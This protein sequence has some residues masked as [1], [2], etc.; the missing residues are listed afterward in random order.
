MARAT[1][2]VR[3]PS[4]SCL[5]H[6]PVR[7]AIHGACVVTRTQNRDLTRV[8]THAALAPALQAHIRLLLL[9]KLILLL[10]LKLELLLL[11]LEPRVFLLLP[12]IQSLVVI[13]IRLCVPLLLLLLKRLLLLLPPQLLLPLRL[14]LLKLPCI[15]RAGARNR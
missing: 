10:L 14:Q 4:A 1:A 5:T 8:V 11:G 3:S 9:L 12:L 15:Q 7:Q 2:K 6:I 13:P